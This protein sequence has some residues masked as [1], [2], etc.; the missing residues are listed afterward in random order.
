LKTLK[1]TRTIKRKKLEEIIKSVNDKINEINEIF[2][3]NPH[4][5]E[6]G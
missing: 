6:M 4:K 3:N 1:N 2:N 5:F